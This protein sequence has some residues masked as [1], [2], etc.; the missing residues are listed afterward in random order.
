LFSLCRSPS[1]PLLLIP[2]RPSS[3]R[4]GFQSRSERSCWRRT[5]PRFRSPRLLEFLPLRP[6]PHQLPCPSPRRL[7]LQPRPPKTPCLRDR[8]RPR[9]HVG[10]R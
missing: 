10:L 9:S 2:R 5:M 3:L 4:P 8:P 6:R 7:R 1:R